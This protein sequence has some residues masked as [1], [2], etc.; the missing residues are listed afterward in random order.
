MST[1]DDRLRRAV[2]ILDRLIAFD[3]TSSRS[4]RDL[5]DWVSDYLNGYGIAATLSS[6]GEGKAN[7]FATIGQG[8]AS[9]NAAA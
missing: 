8:R 4:N 1:S 9:R 7:L 3:T 2:E 6:A 5:I